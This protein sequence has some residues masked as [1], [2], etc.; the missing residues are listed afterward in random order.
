MRGAF[1]VVESLNASEFGP[2]QAIHDDKSDG[3]LHHLELHFVDSEQ[4]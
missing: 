3:L 1:E 2:N 4:L